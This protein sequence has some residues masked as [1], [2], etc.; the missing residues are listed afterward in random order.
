MA[1]SDVRSLIGRPVRAEFDSEH[2]VYV[3]STGNREVLTYKNSLERRNLNFRQYHVDGIALLIASAVGLLIGLLLA[4][5]KLRQ[6]SAA[7]AAQAQE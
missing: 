6:Q 2:D 3:L 5:R 7:L 4:Y 1:E